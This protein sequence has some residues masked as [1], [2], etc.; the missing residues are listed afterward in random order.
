MKRAGKY[1]AAGVLLLLILIPLWALLVYTVVGHVP[2]SELSETAMNRLTVLLGLPVLV[3][4]G[5]LGWRWHAGAASST[6]ASLPVVAV[7][8]SPQPVDPQVQREYVLEVIGLGITFDKYRQGTLWDVLKQGHAYAS[9]REQDPKK[10]PWSAQDKDGQSGGRAVHAFE[11]A[12]KY[13]P[14]FWPMPSFYASPLENPR[15]PTSDTNPSSGIVG[16][17]S[18]TGL[19]WTQFVSAG[20]AKGERPDRMVEQVFAFFDEHPDVPYVVVAASD[21]L[22]DRDRYRPPGT[23]RLVKDGHYVP[24]MPDST[25]MLVLARRERVE[26]VRPYVFK[27]ADRKLSVER[28]HQVSYSWRLGLRFI[29]LTESVPRPK[30]SLSRNP[31]VKEWLQA[32]AEFTQREDIYPK[33]VSMFDRH[34]EG[35]PKGFKPTPWFPLPWNTEQLED[36]DRLPTLGYLHRPVFVKMVDKDDK[37][38]KRQDQRTAALAQGWQEALQT[39]PEGL[40]KTTPAR[41]ITA[42]GGNTDTSVSLHKVLAQW[43]QDGGPELDAAKPNQW[44]NTDARLGN[45]GA[46]TWFMQMGIGV[47]GSYRDGGV[48]AAINFRDPS[49]ASIILITP[50]SGEKRKKQRHPHGGD[51]FRHYATPDIDPANYQ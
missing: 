8:Q 5:F 35:P 25:A 51:V 31:T 40:R 23:P 39:L 2:A 9:V 24:E 43:A 22:Y 46:A 12:A 29:D 32:A 13:L 15:S 45:T 33:T 10:Y 38:L 18:S 49:E 26:A 16:A 14:S 21:D 19:A 1:L 36:F 27:D 50:P 44:V 6:Q 11:N 37:P 20:W 41:V 28:L 42:T 4:V 17:T 48:S 3:V 30:D 34:D 47:M 7:A